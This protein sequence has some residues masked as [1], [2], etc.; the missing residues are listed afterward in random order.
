MAGE[1]RLKCEA[2][3]YHLDPPEEPGPCVA[4]GREVPHW[5]TCDG[6]SACVE[7]LSAKLE[8]AERER[9]A[10]VQSGDLLWAHTVSQSTS[11][12]RARAK[13]QELT[14]PR[15]HRKGADDDL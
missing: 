6:C 14:G 12:Q 15:D 7:R 5:I 11:A 1:R 4:C 3:G 10:L 2:C 9:E 13:W 8:T